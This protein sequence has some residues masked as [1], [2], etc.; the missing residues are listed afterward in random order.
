MVIIGLKDVLDSVVS[1]LVVL[2]SGAC[3][4]SDYRRDV[5]PNSSIALGESMFVLYVESNAGYRVVVVE[6][7]DLISVL[8]YR[9]RRDGLYSD[10]RKCMDS[11]VMVT[12]SE[13]L[14]S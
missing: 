1:K 2:I 7:L 4:G 5:E 12:A 13:L 6:V 11:R 8:A 9:Q 3:L 14:L 10:G